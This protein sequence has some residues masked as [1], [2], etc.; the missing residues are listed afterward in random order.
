MN[1]DIVKRFWNLMSRG[2]F[3]D[4][5]KLMS[6]NCVV[7]FPNTKEVFRGRDKYVK[8]NQKYPGRWIISI[9]KLL[10]N[11]D[12]VVSAANVESEDK[13]SSFYDT[14]FF[15]IRNNVITEITEYWGD[16]GEPPKWRIEEKLSERY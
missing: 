8:M 16:N 12:T 2:M 3:E 13:S 10:S 7:F 4:A 5:G 11:E 9:E 1:K 15:T 6:E 14:A